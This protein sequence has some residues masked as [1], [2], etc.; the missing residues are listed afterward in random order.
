MGE[1]WGRS[2]QLITYF[3]F[4][5]FSEDP[6][7]H[8]LPNPQ[9]TRCNLP[10]PGRRSESETTIRYD[11]ARFGADS[12]LDLRRSGRAV[13]VF[14]GA[15]DQQ[16]SARHDLLFFAYQIDAFSL[17][18]NSTPF[19]ATQN[20]AYRRN[21]V[22][23]FAT[24]A[25]LDRAFGALEFEGDFREFASFVSVADAVVLVEHECR[26][27]GT[28]RRKDAQL[29]RRLVMQRVEPVRV[30]HWNDA[31]TRH[32]QR[33]EVEWRRHIDIAAA[34]EGSTGPKIEPFRRSPGQINAPSPRTGL[35]DAS[36]EQARTEHEVV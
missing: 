33:H 11:C 34:V 8:E 14:D 22:V 7:D 26:F 35:D 19:A 20:D 4:P 36:D 28:R 2:N 16:W 23:S 5:P 30:G 27:A 6:V 21:R 15:W 10:S 32:E 9:L 3:I 24:S 13:R 17:E 1:P 29:P 25:E 31:A 18:R 12:T